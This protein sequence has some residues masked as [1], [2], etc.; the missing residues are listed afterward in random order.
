MNILSKAET[1]ITS[2]VRACK[3][4][5]LALNSLTFFSPQSINHAIDFKMAYYKLAHCLEFNGKI[6]LSPSY[7]IYTWIICFLCNIYG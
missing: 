5:H 4:M 2:Q 6:A 7:L 1:W 3:A